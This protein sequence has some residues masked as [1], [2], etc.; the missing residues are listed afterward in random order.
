M[1]VGLDLA[2][3]D[4]LAHLV[5]LGRQG[6]QQRA[7]DLL[8]HIAPRALALG[9]RGVVVLGDPAGDRGAQGRHVG[10]HLV[11]Q[12]G[13]HVGRRRP[14]LVLGARLVPRAPDPRRDHGGAVVRGE[15]LVGRV[16]DRL[17][18]PG[19][20]GDAGPQVV[21]DDAGRRA[22]QE[23]E[24]VHVAQQPC[25]LLHVERRLDVAVPAEREA[26]HEQVHLPDLAGRGVHEPHRG[27]R[28]VDLHVPAGLVPDATHHVAGH[29]VLPVALAEPIVGHRRRPGLGALVRVLSMQQLERDAGPRELAVDAC[30]V[31]VGV[32]RP[33]VAPAGEQQRVGGLLG[34]PLDVLPGDAPLPRGLEH[35]LDTVL[36]D[37]GGAG[38]RVLRQ[39]VHR[40]QSQ[41]LPG[42]NPSRH[43]EPPR[44]LDCM[45]ARA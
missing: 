14:D 25:I 12:G 26:G 20:G 11:A 34:H 7:L 21:G 18:G 2:T 43:V 33:G 27:P 9:E 17:P 44:S 10:E 16:Q 19:V 32:H 35:V 23:G 36:R 39:P 29:R 45:A 22:S 15:L 42:P 24:G 37:V 5:G 30:P 4:P 38:D 31:R 3:V 1:A 28:P 8:E 6:P 40:P 13:Y 41:D